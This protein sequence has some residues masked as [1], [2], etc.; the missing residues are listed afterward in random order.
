MEEVT[1]K[2]LIRHK[3]PFLLRYLHKNSCLLQESISEFTPVPSSCADA[4]W[5]VWF[6]ANLSIVAKRTLLV[7][8][9]LKRKTSNHHCGMRGELFLSVLRVTPDLQQ[10]ASFDTRPILQLGSLPC[11]CWDLHFT[12]FCLDAKGKQLWGLQNMLV[13]RD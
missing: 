5:S 12:V 7:K 1:Y 3:L 2:S 10:K 11:S 8:T 13:G 6:S 9:F 4:F